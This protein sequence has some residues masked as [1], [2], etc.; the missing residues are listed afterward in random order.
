MKK[1]FLGS[2]FSSALRRRLQP[3]KADAYVG[4]RMRWDEV[5]FRLSRWHFIRNA[6]ETSAL[7]GPCRLCL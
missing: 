6:D 1:P 5:S 3:G 2:A 7:P 4:Q